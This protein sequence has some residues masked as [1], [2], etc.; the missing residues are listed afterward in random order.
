MT[1]KGGKYLE[2]M[3]HADTIVFDKTG[4]L[5]RACPHGGGSD[6][7]GGR[8][9][10][11]MLRPGGLFGGTLPPLHGQCGGTGSPGQRGL[12]PRGDAFSS[13]LFGGSRHCQYR[14]TRSVIIVSAHFVF[15]DEGCTVP[16]EEQEKF[17]ALPDQYTHLYFGH[18]WGP[19]CGHLHFRPSAA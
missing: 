9:E 4:T 7:F 17:D 2:A 1:V 3:A 12:S 18:C 8:S 11:D 15:E 13:G 10:T 14:G 19:C 5:T 6:S 16:P